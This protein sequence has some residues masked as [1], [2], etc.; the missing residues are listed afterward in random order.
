MTLKPFEPRTVLC[1][2]DFSDFS[3]PSLRQAVSF[4]RRSNARVVALHV[5][6]FAAP[7]RMSAGALDAGFLDIPPAFLAERRSDVAKQLR[8]VAHICASEGVDIEIEIREG[9]PW[10]EIEATA[11]SLPAD[12]VVLGTHGRGGWDRFVMG[13]TTE[14]LIRRLPCPVLTLGP[15]QLEQRGPS[16]RIVLCAVDLTPEST[17][18]LDLSLA[19][20]EKTFAEVV[21]LHV[22][23][24][25]RL[26]WA[27]KGPQGFATS[28]VKATISDA[29]ERL[30]QMILSSKSYATVASR[31]ATG[32]A[33]REIVR[34][35][36][37]IHADLIVVGAHGQKDMGPAFL[38][39]T[40]SHVIRHATCPVLLAR[41]IE[42]TRVEHGK[43]A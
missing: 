15:P 34:A 10:R 42:H 6:P 32:T 1:P 4:A 21:L 30:K 25:G 37:E 2:L 40:A 33:W 20:A 26:E 27:P 36:E 29:E 17:V 5:I 39:S 12:L 35:A 22:V 24:S 16:F 41:P 11:R 3:E 18:T 31:I 13:S 7:P 43:V 28:F 8:D 23:D 9:D 14:K 38:G 19:F